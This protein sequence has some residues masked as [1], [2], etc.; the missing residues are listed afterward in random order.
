MQ[1]WEYLFVQPLSSITNVTR[2][3]FNDEVEE[4]SANLEEWQIANE[5]GAQGWEL[6]GIRDGLYNLVFKRP[7]TKRP[8]EVQAPRLTS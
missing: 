2:L 6:V 1:E 5:L 7:R 4:R 3:A 8:E